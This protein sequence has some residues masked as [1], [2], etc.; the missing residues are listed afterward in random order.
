MP[1]SAALTLAELLR[2][3]AVVRKLH[4]GRINIGYCDGHVSGDDLE[5]VF[6]SAADDALRRWNRDH[7]SHR[8][9][10]GL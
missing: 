7:E 6:F 9:W 1:G 10:L 8:E 2:R 3:D 4:V 5:L